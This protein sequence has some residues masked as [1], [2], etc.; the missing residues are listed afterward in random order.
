VVN[1]TDSESTIAVSGSSIL[2]ESATGSSLQGGQLA[3][4]ANTTIW[5]QR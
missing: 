1:T 4:A 3:I 2:L 5:L